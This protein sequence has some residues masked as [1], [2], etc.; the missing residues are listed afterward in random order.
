VVQMT[1]IAIVTKWDV[2][3]IKVLLAAN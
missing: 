1:V 3:A 2:L